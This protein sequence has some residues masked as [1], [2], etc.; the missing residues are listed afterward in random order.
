MAAEQEE[1]PR[2]PQSQS[3]H[4]LPD[5]AVNMRN[6]SLAVL[7][8][9]A[10]V[11]ALRWAAP[12]FIPLMMSLLLTYALSPVVARLERWRVSPWIGSAI[13]LLS[14]VGAMGWTTYSLSGSA[15]ALLDAL[16]VAAQKLQLMVVT[17][18][19]GDTS[20]LETVQKAAS[21]LEQAA[22]SSAAHARPPRGV[23]RVAV[24]RPRFNVR[25]Y[26]WTG[27]VGLIGAAGQLTMVVFLSYFALGSGTT[28]R[29]KLVKISGASLQKRRSRCMCWTTSPA[30]SSAIC[31][32]RS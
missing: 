17:G 23:V 6:A 29:R 31:W 26:L 18:N 21:Q 27:T 28:F 4:V 19:K 30:T 16:P 8:V 7:T 1:A 25:D 13:V 15:G 14:L 5:E 3:A 32:C 24:E 11:F 10:C 12:V 9:L 2:T 20:A 22:E